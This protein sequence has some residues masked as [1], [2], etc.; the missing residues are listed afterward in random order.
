MGLIQSVEDLST[1]K[2]LTKRKLLL[3]D[4]E[5]EILFVFSSLQIYPEISVLLGS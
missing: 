3:P 4:Y 2:M 1:T 5:G